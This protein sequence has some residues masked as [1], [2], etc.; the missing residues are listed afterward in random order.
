VTEPNTSC[1]SIARKVTLFEDRAEVVR[2]STVTLGAGNQRVRISGVTLLVDDRSLQVRLADTAA[3]EVLAAKIVRRRVPALDDDAR[4][5]DAAVTDARAAQR[6]AA[7]AVGRINATLARSRA[8]LD[9]W[10][11]GVTRVPTMS[12]EARKHWALA[13]ER[14][15][16]GGA[17]AAA[18]TAQAGWE[19]SQSRE[20]V[21]LAQKRLD[22]AR[23]V[24]SE[25][26]AEVEVQ[27]DVAQPIELELEITYRTPAALWRPEHLLR[28][29]KTDEG[30]VLEWTTMATSWQITGEDWAGVEALYSTARPASAANAPRLRDDVL[31]TRRKSDEERKQVQVESRDMSVETARAHGGGA[32][33]MMGVDDG[34]TP[35]LLEA[36]APV[37]LPSTG[38]PHRVRV[39]EQRLPV[40]V[41]RVLY[42]ELGAVA[43]YA[44][45]GVLSGGQCM[46]AGPAHIA[47]GGSFVGRTRVDFIAAGES[48]ELGFGPD[49]G[50]RVRRRLKNERERTPVLG[51]QTV[52]RRVFVFVSNLSDD[53]R[54]LHV[55]ERVPVSEI[56]AVK[57]RVTHA[58]G[59]DW[60]E[61]D[62]FLS[63]EL[64]LEA[65]ETAELELAWEIRAGSDVVLPF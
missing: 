54:E 16:E 46:L 30:H 20:E 28:L 47:R 9:T 35:V 60:E 51:T 64:R 37:D 61:R 49:D 31:R 40:T 13:G 44:A 34:G 36:P 1:P 29:A 26:V 32:A 14:L 41:R 11:E 59:W 38:E 22:A 45:R 65:H 5:L 42:P 52:S 8:L 57:V 25:Y 21:T 24:S 27:L 62:G 4:E 19:A 63:R 23:Y 58:E 2:T 53:A 39:G 18:Q 3:A 43:H 48:F 56:D 15:L 55:V 17:A 7:Q 10:L 50:V 12:P 33:E 6:A